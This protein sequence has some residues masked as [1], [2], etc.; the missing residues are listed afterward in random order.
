MTDMMDSAPQ[1][2]GTIDVSPEFVEYYNSLPPEEQERLRNLARDNIIAAEYGSWVEYLD[3][4]EIG[5]LLKKAEKEGWTLDTLKREIRKTTWYTS[6]ARVVREFDIRRI[7]DPATVDQEINQNAMSI[8][9]VASLLGGSLT[10]EQ[11]QELSTNQLRLG[12]N[13]AET[14]RA[15]ALEIGKGSDPEQILRR[16]ITGESVTRVASEMAVP[17]SDAA[18]NDWTKK[19]AFGQ[20]TIEDF[21]NW[22]KTQASSLYPTLA[23]DIERGFTVKSLSDPFREVASRTLGLNPNEIDFA[24]P[25]WNAALN[26]DDGKGRRMMT[27]YEWGRH[28]RTNEEYGYDRTPEATNKAYNMIDRLGRAFGVTA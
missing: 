8:K 10:D 9:Q 15:V 21:Q 7:E 19:I 5:P 23:A 28:L 1:A 20:V 22:A 6:T 26:F 11:A 4:P 16:G 3:H 18:I 13:A 27:L 25:R 12:W 17:M 24:D 14:T 2:A